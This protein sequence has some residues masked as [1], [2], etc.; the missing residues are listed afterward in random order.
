MGHRNSQ[1][2]IS[3]YG[4]P[5]GI[6]VSIIIVT[7]L[8][9]SIEEENIRNELYTNQIEIQQTVTDGIARNINAELKIIFLELSILSNSNELQDDFNSESSLDLMRNTYQ[10]IN[11]ITPITALILTDDE[12]MVVSHQPFRGSDITGLRLTGFPIQQTQETLESQI[13]SWTGPPI[14]GYQ[15]AMIHPVI[16]KDDGKLL[17]MILVGIPAE[18]F[19][20][21]HGNIYDIDS[22][23][24]TAFDKRQHYMVNPNE[25]LVG[26][27]FFG[28]LV[29]QF[30]NRNQIL[31]THYRNLFEGNSTVAIYDLGV[32]EVINTATPVAI[33]END[34]LFISVITPTATIADRVNHIIA[35]S[36]II[37]TTILG[38]IAFILVLFFIKRSKRLEKEKLAI[39]G[40]LSS[41][42]AHDMRNPLGTIRSSLRRIEKQN[43]S[44]NQ[45]VTDETNRIKRS[46]NRMS[47]QVEQ[48]LNYVRTT[49]LVEK[50]SSLLEML[51]YAFDSVEIPPN[52]KITIPENNLKIVCDSE[53]LEIVFINLI[54][55][56][57]Q[58]IGEDQGNIA[59]RA[60]EKENQ[61]VLEFENNG[62]NIPQDVLPKIF[63]P[64]FTTKL[65]GTGLGLSG[66][67]NIIE[68]HKGTIKVSSSPVIF[69]ITLPKSTENSKNK[70]KGI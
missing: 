34:S 7:L 43:V 42:I 30:Y 53:K 47:H 52:V 36:K 51:N 55:N 25:E 16:D 35:L 12:G 17:G 3:W 68:Q 32:G 59:I 31:N 65:K 33:S 44:K 60:K 54:L 15:L 69:T 21:R 67:K 48:V 1:K 4:V 19:F 2:K 23:F 58:A 37:T 63:D 5:T 18:Q 11:S 6:V 28:P 62:P 38:F 13:S 8:I 41:N 57:V 22:R 27:P 61:F 29:Q 50:D 14:F 46:I 45:I 64:L 40:Q 10:K 56:A 39:I 9:H 49:P 70:E 20:L 66:C 26:H 24:L